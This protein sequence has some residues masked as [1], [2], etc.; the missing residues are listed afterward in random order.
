LV[1]VV[2][3]FSKAFVGGCRSSV[4]RGDEAIGDGVGGIVEVTTVIHAEDR[5]S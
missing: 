1:D 4:H 2:V 3:G 5:F